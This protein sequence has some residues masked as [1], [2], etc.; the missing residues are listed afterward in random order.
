MNND[1]FYENYIDIISL[2]ICKIV[3]KYYKNKKPDCY[4]NN[5]GKFICYQDNNK[6]RQHNKKTVIFH[7]KIY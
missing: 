1:F 5:D 2:I 3:L 6:Y 7:I 4:I